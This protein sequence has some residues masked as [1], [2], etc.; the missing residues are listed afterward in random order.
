LELCGEGSWLDYKTLKKRIKAMPTYKVDHP[1]AEEQVQVLQSSTAARDF[2][3]MLRKELKKVANVYRELEYKALRE[4]VKLR[5]LVA[6]LNNSNYETAALLE[7][8]KNIHMRFLMTE[9]YAVLNYGGFVKILKKHDKKTGLE[10]QQK[11]L[12]RLVNEQ[13]FALH[14]WLRSAIEG[15]EEHFTEISSRIHSTNKL[16]LIN[17]SH[18]VNKSTTSKSN[19]VIKSTTAKSAVESSAAVQHYDRV[20]EQHALLKGSES[21]EWLQNAFSRANIYACLKSSSPNTHGSDDSTSSHEDISKNRSQTNLPF[22]LPRTLEL[23]AS[24]AQKLGKRNS[25]PGISSSS[26]SETEL[27]RKGDNKRNYSMQRSNSDSKK[28]KKSEL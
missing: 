27:N 7:Q 5:T 3:I 1:T 19:S 11:F 16:H 13:P 26:S 12:L 20:L 6:D 22:S 14:P 18:S 23:L 9:N 25:Q 28:Q 24:A 10:T 8:C 15:V 2:F 4:L 21:S 17:K